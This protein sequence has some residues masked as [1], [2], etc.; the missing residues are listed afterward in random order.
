[1]ICLIVCTYRG[2]LFGLNGKSITRQYI[3]AAVY[4]PVVYVCETV[5]CVQVLYV[6]ECASCMFLVCAC[7]P[8]HKLKGVSQHLRGFENCDAE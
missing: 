8:V 3:Q 7:V 5:A 6:R 1:M 4:V 2:V